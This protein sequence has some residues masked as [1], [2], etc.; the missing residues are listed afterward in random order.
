M[1]PEVAPAPPAQDE[2]PAEDEGVLTQLFSPEG[3]RK[4]KWKRS[5]PASIAKAKKK[6]EE[7]K[8]KGYTFFR[9]RRQKV[10]KFPEKNGGELVASAKPPADLLPEGTTETFEPDDKELVA[11]GRARGG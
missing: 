7:L 11:V 9:V 5:D 3:D 2:E 8:A 1:A 10:D 6:F 4:L